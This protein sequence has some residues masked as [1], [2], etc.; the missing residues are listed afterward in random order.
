MMEEPVEK[1]SDRRIKLNCG[2][3]QMTISSARRERCVAVIAD[4]GVARR[5]AEAERFGGHVPVDGKAGAGQRR[6]AERRFIHAPDRVAE[7]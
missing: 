3:D 5:L 4:D 6:R 2:V 7:P 1:L